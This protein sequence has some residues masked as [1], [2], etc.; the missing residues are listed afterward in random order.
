MQ[1]FFKNYAEASMDDNAE[2]IASFYSDNFLMIGPS[3]SVPFSNNRK[4]VGWLKKVIAY[5]K[6]TGL[7]K[8]SVRK[9]T[10][11][12]I[13]K[14]LKQATVTWRAIFTKTN[15][16]FIEFK[17]HYI[18]TTLG[19]QVKIVS[20]ASEEDQEKLMREKKII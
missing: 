18:L 13:G 14:V 4:F 3:G 11:R 20:Y 1:N 19:G 9:V 2:A 10:S 17:I 7:K 16:E 15:N 5:N 12:S 6:K 8:M